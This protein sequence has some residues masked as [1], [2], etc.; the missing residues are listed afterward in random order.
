[1]VARLLSHL[2]LLPAVDCQLPAIDGAISSVVDACVRCDFS[3]MAGGV[4]ILRRA[5]HFTPVTMLQ[6]DMRST[7][8]ALLGA[9]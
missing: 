5:S 7:W 8:Y 1:M 9:Q 6:L 2:L 4:E 3:W